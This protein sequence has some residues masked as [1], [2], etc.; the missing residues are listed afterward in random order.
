MTPHD[1]PGRHDRVWLQPGWSHTLR[2]PLDPIARAQVQSWVDGGRPLVVTRRLPDDLPGD[3]RLGLALPGRRRVAVHVERQAIAR[4]APPPG[5]GDVLA[6]APALWRGTL[7]WLAAMTEAL[8]VPTGLYG[9][10]AWQYAAQDEAMTY[11]TT[12]SDLDLLFR[13]SDWAT[14]ERLLRELT[15]H[16]ARSETPRLDG[17]IV[18]PDGSAVAWRELA[19]APDKILSKSLDS[20]ALRPLAAIMALFP[21]RPA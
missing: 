8:A 9:S 4:H 11:L 1:G 21:R 19:A 18:L 16:E 14:V 13:P 5:L 7:E 6:M 15:G 12:G 2:T 20:V 10:L 3:V 17:E